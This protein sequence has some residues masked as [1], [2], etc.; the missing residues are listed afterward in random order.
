M[1]RWV[2]EYADILLRLV[3]GQFCAQRERVRNR[4]LKIDDLEV[5]VDEHLLVTLGGRPHRADVVRVALH[6]EVRHTLANV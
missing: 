1:S 2:E 5:K 4:F 6:G 3:V